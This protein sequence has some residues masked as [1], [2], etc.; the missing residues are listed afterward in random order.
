MRES[1]ADVAA[2]EDDDI[3]MSLCPTPPVQQQPT[4]QNRESSVTQ[5]PNSPATTRYHGKDP[6]DPVVIEQPKSY[7]SL[8]TTV[9]GYPAA[10]TVVTTILCS[11]MPTQV[12]QDHVMLQDS[13]N[14]RQLHSDTFENDSGIGRSPLHNTT[15]AVSQKLL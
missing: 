6:G 10:E 9:N 3:I 2:R 13:S 5:I 8:N 1:A 15:S 12:D 4:R 14:V 11:N 7:L